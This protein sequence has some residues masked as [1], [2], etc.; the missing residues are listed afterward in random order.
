MHFGS[1]KIF[2]LFMLEKY[3]FEEIFSEIRMLFQKKFHPIMQTICIYVYIQSH[4]DIALTFKTPLQ[5]RYWHHACLELKVK[6]M[7][8]LF[9]RATGSTVYE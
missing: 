6:K 2:E 4:H 1:Y 3:R 7:Q 9:A 5:K 8:V